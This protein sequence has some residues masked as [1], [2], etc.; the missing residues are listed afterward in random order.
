M[1]MLYHG[2]HP[3]HPLRA[4]KN[5]KAGVLCSI[6]KSSAHPSMAEWHICMHEKCGYILCSKCSE[7]DEQMLDVPQVIT[8]NPVLGHE[9]MTVCLRARPCSTAQM[10]SPLYSSQL[11]VAVSSAKGTVDANETYYRVK[12][13]GWLNVSHVV[14]ILPSQKLVKELTENHLRADE[15]QSIEL[16]DLKALFLCIDESFRLMDDRSPYGTVMASLTFF[17]LLQYSSSMHLLSPEDRIALL[18]VALGLIHY[19]FHFVLDEVSEWMSNAEYRVRL[20][21]LTL[22]VELLAKSLL[23]VRNMA[24]SQILALPHRLGPL[25]TRTAAVALKLIP[26]VE[27]GLPPYENVT[28]LLRAPSV[29]GHPVN[30]EEGKSRLYS[31]CCNMV[32]TAGWL[33]LH[34]PTF[35]YD[36]KGLRPL[37]A[38]VSIV[39]NSESLERML[40]CVVTNALERMPS[41]QRRVHEL[42]VIEVAI[43]LAKREISAES[44]MAVFGLI[45]AIAHNSPSN[46][47]QM[48]SF[49]IAPLIHLAM[50]A[51]NTAVANAAFDCFVELTH[52]GRRLDDPRAN[53]HNEESM[54]SLC[55]AALYPQEAS[56]QLMSVYDVGDHR[57]AICEFCRHSHPPVGGV[58]L[59]DPQFAYF[60]CQCQSCA[61][62]PAPHPLPPSNVLT[63]LA[64]QK[65]L[66]EG[67]IIVM[68]SW[69][70]RRELAVVNAV[71]R[72]ALKIPVPVEVPR[73]LYRAL[74]EQNLL[75]YEDAVLA[76]AVQSH[77]P[78][79]REMQRDHPSA[80]IS[81]YL[82]RL[83]GFRV[84]AFAEATPGK[85][86]QCEDVDG[87]TPSPD[88]TME[89]DGLCEPLPYRASLPLIGLFAGP[90]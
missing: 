76:I 59:C 36:L 67:I 72:L 48:V 6:C 46:I 63:T 31:Y 17:P 2:S 77:L 68:L 81:Q 20:T 61:Y 80:A 79:V 34:T 90:Q 78:V 11:M 13:G 89:K 57:Q 45:A 86:S 16:M 35:T 22:Y 55:S 50:E 70:K 15:Q 85:G 1:T 18:R 4:L 29:A 3:A 88:A 73:A 52:N 14:R 82:S 66:K 51:R 69:L 87:L 10:L 27:C 64:I 75:G 8:R 58:P 44:Q 56:Y 33:L 28:E 26:V 5:P 38:A 39:P 21:L 7:I 84:A 53:S 37:R 49:V 41:L 60:R 65:M 47:S 19:L 32:E 12:A 40:C 25:I 24:E 43:S 9:D 54:L 83:P 74:L 30:V 62:V 71:G 42:D 23:V